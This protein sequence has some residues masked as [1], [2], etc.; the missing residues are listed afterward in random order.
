MKRSVKGFLVLFFGLVL[1]VH[2][3]AFAAD[4]EDFST[5]PMTNN[6]EKWRIGYYEGGEYFEYQLN[7]IMMVKGLMELGWIETAKIPE[8][9]GE[10]TKD[11]WNWLVTK[12]KSKYIQ[13]VIDAHYTAAWDNN[14][15]K[16]MASEIVSRLNQ[17]KDIDL[18]LAMGT[19]AG[20]D[21]A[22]DKH[23]I[24][25]M[26]IGTANPL[27]SGIIKSVEDS[28]YD[29]VHARI[30]QFRFD[31]QL[32]IFHDIIE[33]KKLGVVYENTPAGRTYSAMDE[34]EKSAEENGFEIIRCHALSD[35]DVEI[36]AKEVEKCF[37]ELV[38]KADAIYVPVHGGIISKT[39]P[40]LVE[41]V[42]SNHIPTFVM[43]GSEHVKAGFLMS[44][45][46]AGFKYV[47]KF[48]AETMAKIF[49]GAKPREL[50]QLF[51]DPSKI[52]I[53]LK[54]AAIIGFNIPVDVIGVADEIYVEITPPKE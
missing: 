5:D 40:T 36:A 3:S 7:F 20:K 38:K 35:V 29:H 16:Q 11:I 13:F 27:Q 15:R 6:G 9:K 24:P 49:N 34:V 23:N 42:N 1:L 10:Q 31:R 47:G 53:N 45:S 41:I 48:Y 26:V 52:A 18:F 43:T 2:V 44:L 25:T 21:M 28:G 22:N 46:M 8:Q 14:I 30:D 32:R 4:N 33:F 39:V 54:T 50:P 37:R 51:E 17:K 12:A 19:W